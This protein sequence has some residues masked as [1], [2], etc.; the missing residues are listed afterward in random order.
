MPGTFNPYASFKSPAGVL[1]MHVS[2][3]KGLMAIAAKNG[4]V[5]GVSLPDKRA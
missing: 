3:A 2:A 5:Y 4:K 1:G